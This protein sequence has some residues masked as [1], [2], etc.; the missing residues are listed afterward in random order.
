[1]LKS[2]A[3]SLSF[4][5]LNSLVRTACCLTFFQSH[6]V[7]LSCKK[8][9]SALRALENKIQDQSLCSAID[10]VFVQNTRCHSCNNQIVKDR[11][12]LL[13]HFEL[14]GLSSERPLDSVVDRGR[15]QHCF[16][17][18]HRPP[19]LF[20]QS[21]WLR[22]SPFQPFGSPLLKATGQVGNRKSYVFCFRRQEV[23]WN[24][25]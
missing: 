11:T 4:A 6:S 14:A 18:G 24:S 16:G 2:N 23:A 15:T 22:P 17:C 10:P 12:E 1:M 20:G 8:T 21:Q 7:D 3:R 25:S 9:K 19:P 13:V 5:S